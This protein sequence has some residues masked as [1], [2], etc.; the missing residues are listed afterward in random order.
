M[1]RQGAVMFLERGCNCSK[2]GFYAASW[3]GNYDVHRPN[4]TGMSRVELALTLSLIHTRRRP[5]VS[6]HSNIVLCLP[7]IRLPTHT[8]FLLYSMHS[9]VPLPIQWL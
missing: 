3:I 4:Q 9:R 8:K 7:F 5:S 6:V 1:A 2:G